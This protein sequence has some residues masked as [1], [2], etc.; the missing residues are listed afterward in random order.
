LS[1]TGCHSIKRNELQAA[2]QKNGRLGAIN[3][4]WAI[5]QPTMLRILA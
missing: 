4:V 3:W 5:V 1:S 2:L